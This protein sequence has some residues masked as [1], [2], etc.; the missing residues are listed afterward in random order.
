MIKNPAATKKGDIY[1][2]IAHDIKDDKIVHYWT[3]QDF[4]NF[5]GPFVVSCDDVKDLLSLAKDIIEITDEEGSLIR[6]VWMPRTRKVKN[7]RFKFPLVEGF[8]DPQ[9]FPWNGKWYFIATN[10]VNHNIG[11]HVREADTVDD[12]F[13]DKHRSQ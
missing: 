13:T 4:V 6:T 2:I 9:V 12:L 5:K 3:T 1:Y 7:I 10:D 11:L 8:A